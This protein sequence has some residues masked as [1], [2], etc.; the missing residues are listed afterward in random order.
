MK[1]HS[2][3]T[4]TDAMID[5]RHP[6]KVDSA[7]W[8]TEHLADPDLVDHDREAVFW[9]EGFAH[10]AARGILG[11]LV[12]AE[13]GGRERSIADALLELEGL[14][15]GCAD[16]GLA[17]AA[18]AQIWSTQNALVRFGSDE[19]RHRHLAPMVSGASIGAFCM[20]EPASGSDAFA[21]STTADRRGDVY[22]LNGH[23]TWI[24]LG[25]IADVFVVFASTRPDAGQWGVS[26]FIV[27]ASSPG[28]VASP[29][30]EKMGL[31]TVPF[32]DVVLDECPVPV[33]NRL[34]PEGAGASM[35]AKVLDDERSFLFATELG[36]V[37]RQLDTAIEFAR[38]RTQFGQPIGSFQAVS[39]RIAE[40]KLR[41]ETARLLMYKAALLA[42]QG[43]SITMTSALSKLHSTESALANALD[44]VR[45]HGAR[46]YVSE[47]GIE[48]GVRDAIG[49]LLTSG[50]SDIQM[51]IVAAMLGVK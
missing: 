12:P 13:Y 25:P 20:S 17:F 28:V 42:E 18:A 11:M 46:G 1:T 43:E 39:H 7:A 15:Y 3:A 30:R 50:T 44:A 26:A 19:Q 36:A 51:N 35:F 37:E 41:H 40:M 8:A 2:A 16:H 31:R 5:L 38:E 4:A 33:A 48:R 27:D 49:S 23:K 9:R 29:N 21:L 22:V 24:T 10:I 14:G 45:I 6:T 32:G 47:F 34:G